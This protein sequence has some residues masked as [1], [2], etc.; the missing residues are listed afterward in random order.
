M[1]MGDISYTLIPWTLLNYSRLEIFIRPPRALAVVVMEKKKEKTALRCKQIEYLISFFYCYS[2]SSWS[3]QD[4]MGFCCMPC[5]GVVGGRVKTFFAIIVNW[6][7]IRLVLSVGWC[8][9]T[10]VLYSGSFLPFTSVQNSC[11]HFIYRISFATQIFNEQ[12]KE[13]QIKLCIYGFEGHKAM[14]EF[15]CN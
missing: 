6:T 14:N 13:I 1:S 12:R 8:T 11:T 2:Q 9:A 10:F 15:F 3:E 4:N 5:T 7:I